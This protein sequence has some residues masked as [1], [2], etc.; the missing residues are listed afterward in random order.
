MIECNVSMN[1]AP[2]IGQPVHRAE[3]LRFLKGAGTFVDDVR[4]EGM[5]HAVVLRSP[6]AHGRVRT[7]DAASART[8]P[9]VHAVITAADVGEIPVIPLR[10]ANL[11]EFKDYLQPVIA[12]DKVRYVGEPVAVVIADSQAR[13]EDAL[14]AVRVE[15]EPLP[16]IADR[17]A[18]ESGQALLF[19]HSGRN[20][21]VRYAVSFGDANAAFARAEYT[22]KE[23]FRC[24][25]LTG[26]PLE[27]RGQV[28][29]WNAGR[30]TVFGATKVL[31]FNRR[32]LAPMLGVAEDA[33]DMIEVD[34]GGGFGVRGEF[35]PED[36]LIPF[37]ARQVGRPVK[38]IEDRREHLVATNHSRE[39][40][41]EIEIACRRDGTILGMRGHVYSDMGAYIRTNGGV[42]PAKAAQFL[43][44]PYR[45]RDVAVTVDVLVT[46]KTPV[47][48]L[49]APGRFE[50]NFFRE[51]L[52]DIVAGDLGLDPMAFR[53][54]NLIAEAEL[55]FHTGKL[56]PYE[57]ETD[58][59]TGDYHATFERALTEIGWTR[60]KSLQG[61]LIDGRYHGLAAVP[62]VESGGS[63]KENTR[64]R[65]E[66][67]GSV[68]VYVGSSVLGQGLET[69]LA[70]VA[71]DALKLPFE[72][73]RIL[74]GSTT[75]LREGFGTFASRSMVVGGSA[76]LDG[77]NNL[78]AAVR[79]AATERFG[80][81]NEQVEIAGG[82]VS[83]GGKR[84]G[85]AEFAGLEAEGTF[86]TTTRT[87]SYGAHACHVAID[88]RTGHVEI[89]DYV[90]IEDVGVAINPH[91]VH[92]QAIGALVQGLGGVFLDQIMYD[93]DAQML[94]ASL[95][96]YLVPLATDFSN[97]RAITMELRRSK[98]NPLGA[99]G[100][101]EGGMVAVA[102]TTANAVAAAL[103]PLGVEVRDLP[104][105]PANVWALVQARV[106]A[107][108]K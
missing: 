6:V 99:K 44:G 88:P 7:I 89:L 18:A 93:R 50:A 108:G 40:E 34:V 72:R 65:I 31:F 90:A 66:N 73:I 3:D 46:S 59:D 41:C 12:K 74:H 68:T 63:G 26:L 83:A 58:F 76:V 25:R 14:E 38:W 54:K 86:A 20:R 5:L 71:A 22:R 17:H 97:I 77:C 9:G 80:L 57:P 10:L 4:R 53:L 100:A 106:T 95:A 24:H 105:S 62:F 98:T 29:E 102:A 15:I 61:R 81:P 28:A 91:I 49:R 84:A 56:V 75:Y 52:L 104:L 16:A 51:R 47:G 33:I 42:V 43:P 78:L 64:V 19:E 85:L 87:Y 21:A 30:L 67:D 82:M 79:A 23:R 70:Q 94:N 101:G 92:G 13:A 60:N 39:V 35:Y 96:D 32:A 27:T 37:A 103:A 69:T 1:V 2:L 48:T 8:M 45:I 36:F 107:V 11:P 55:P